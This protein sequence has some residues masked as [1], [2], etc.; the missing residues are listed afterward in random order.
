MQYEEKR[1]NNNGH[2]NMAI[3]NFVPEIQ[4]VHQNLL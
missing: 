3:D 2:L 4:P 1:D